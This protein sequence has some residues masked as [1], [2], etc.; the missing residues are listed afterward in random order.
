MAPAASDAAR[1]TRPANVRYFDH[2]LNMQGPRQLF[3]T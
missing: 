1:K 3:E 2:H